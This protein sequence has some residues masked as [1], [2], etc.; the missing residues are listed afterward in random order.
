MDPLRWE[1]HLVEVKYCDDTLFC[2]ERFQFLFGLQVFLALSMRP[3]FGGYS[4][5]AQPFYKLF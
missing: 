2:Y 1:V 4:F 3:F 5:V